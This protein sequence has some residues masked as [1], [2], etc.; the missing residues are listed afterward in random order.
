MEIRLSK[1]PNSQEERRKLI[2]EIIKREQ[3]LSA[4]TIG[5]IQRLMIEKLIDLGYK[6]SDIYFNKEYEVI[7]SERERF[8]TS[9]DILL[10]IDGKVL[11]AIKCTPASIESW[12]RFMFAFCRVVEPYQIPFAFI[13]DSKEGILIDI[14]SGEVKQTM[15]FPSKDE[16]LRK[17]SYMEFIP[18]DKER[19]QKEK[20]ILYAFDAIK[21]CPIS[22]S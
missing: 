6:L 18:Y 11:F 15:E 20:R 10:V 8:V 14:L 22:D 21:C 2:E 9:V 4:K 1:I 19:L 16:L 5:Y 7:V 13:T 12:E 3:E 17:I